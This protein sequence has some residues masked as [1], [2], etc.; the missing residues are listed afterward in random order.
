MT[1]PIASI[2]LLT[3]KA[4]SCLDISWVRMALGS[5]VVGRRICYYPRIDS[6]NEQA[7]RL[8]AADETEGTVVVAETQTAGRGRRGRRWLDEPGSTLLFSV[9]LR[10]VCKASWL[11]V[12]SLGAAAACAESLA[13]GYS[14]P[15][16]IKWPNDLLIADRKVGGILLE[17]RGDAVVV[18]IGLNVN[19]PSESLQV[20]VGT[21]LTTLESH[22]GAP[23]PREE[24]LVGIL[25]KMDD[26]YQQFRSAGPAAV[27]GRY[28]RFESVLGQRVQISVGQEMICG[29]A[30]AVTDTGTLV[31]DTAKGRR[32]ITAGEVELV[33]R[34]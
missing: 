4:N 15:V 11:P 1:E 19:G 32:E 33:T 25:G 26:T 17:R 12:L 8:A 24:V 28:R 20:R 22:Y 29:M 9:L 34:R 3:M 5:K 16:V 27:V 31:V 21:L 6:T 14:L 10:P 2:A 23:L 30:M 7:L 18:G 13:S